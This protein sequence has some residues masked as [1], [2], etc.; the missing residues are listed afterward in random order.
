MRC[1][2]FTN[3]YNFS[4]ELVNVDKEMLNV[5]N[6][7]LQFNPFFRKSA[8]NCLNSPL[9]K[10][11]DKDEK[12]SQQKIFLEC[13]EYDED[14]SKSLLSLDDYINII[15]KEAQEIH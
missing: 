14:N 2:N 9:F 12:K 5:L 13:D 6:N 1:Q 10:N 4:D 11:V 7:M 15:A 8:G 3:L